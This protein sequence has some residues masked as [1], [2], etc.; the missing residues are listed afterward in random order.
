MTKKELLEN[1]RNHIY[2]RIMPSPIHGV[3]VFAIRKIPKGINPFVGAPKEEYIPLTVKE[4]ASL[5]PA[6]QRMVKDFCF[7]RDEVY[8][9]SPH[10]LY[11]LDM[12][13]F[14]NHSDNPNLET[15]GEEFYTM[16]EIDVDEELT[17]DYHTFCEIGVEE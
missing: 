11:H 13:Y 9:S 8:W 1:F 12:V 2:C 3:G 4:V 5:D 14:L 15:R 10:G 7:F 16:R 6:V 17:D